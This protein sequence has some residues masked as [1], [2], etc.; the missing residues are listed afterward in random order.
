MSGAAMLRIRLQ[1]EV[2]FMFNGMQV[3]DFVVVSLAVKM[4]SAMAFPNGIVSENGVPDAVPQGGR[5][6]LATAVAEN[7]RGSPTGSPTR[8]GRQLSWYTRPG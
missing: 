3:R 2:L 7:V 1:K 4:G 8:I 5:C 6:S